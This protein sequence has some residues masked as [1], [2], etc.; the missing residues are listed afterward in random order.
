MYAENGTKLRTGLAELLRQHRIQ[1]RIGGR[2]LYTVPETT[3]RAERAELGRLI[4]TYRQGVLVWCRDTAHAIDP[5]VVSNVTHLP[6]NPFVP[7]ERDLG[8][9]DSLKRALDATTDASNAPMPTLEDLTKRHP[10]PFVETW[11]HVA[12]AAAL[13]EHDINQSPGQR[14]LT[15]QQAL[16]VAGDIAAISQA[17]IVLDRRYRNIPE[18][19]PLRSPT[20]LGWAALACA[21]DA[22]LGAPDFSVDEHGWRPPVKLMRGPPRLGLLGALQSEHNLLVRLGTY[23]SALNLRL[24]VDS[25]RMISAGLADRAA[26]VDP[27]LSEAWHRRAHTYGL[28]QRQLRNVGSLLGKGGLAAA[29]GANAL[30]RLRAVPADVRPEPHLLAA[31]ATLFARIDERIADI[32]DDSLQRGQLV[33]RIQARKLDASTSKLIHQT[34]ATF[35]PV[36]GPMA[37]RLRAICRHR[38]RPGQSQTAA[39]AAEL[40]SRAELHAALVHEPQRRSAGPS[41]HL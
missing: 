28:L 2:G 8:P 6:P 1:H 37:T 39:E 11:R 23:P 29:E 13:S 20:Q 24:V 9:L 31:F 10:L 17:L 36:T 35:I 25:Q 21:A 32:V 12:R 34:Q 3:S 19:E 16:A 5:Y 38:L 33:E 41:M 30:S 14:A 15:V 4:L 27:R 26:T 22:N 18:W 7:A 40:A